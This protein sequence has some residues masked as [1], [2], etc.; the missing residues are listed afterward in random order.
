MARPLP[1]MPL[2]QASTGLV[3]SIRAIWNDDR[4]TRWAIFNDH[5][6]MMRT[7]WPFVAGVI[8]VLAI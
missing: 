2:A 6:N 8:F 3:D 4:R 5:V 7:A 1:G